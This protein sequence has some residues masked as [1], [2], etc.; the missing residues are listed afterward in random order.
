M[1]IF[2]ESE[3][4]FLN[5]Q[6]I[7]FDQYSKL[8]NT[9][10]PLSKKLLN[11]HDILN[12]IIK[13]PSKEKK[14]KNKSL[15]CSKMYNEIEEK[16]RCI[17]NLFGLSELGTETDVSSTDS[18]EIRKSTTINN[19]PEY[20][21]KFFND[22]NELRN[23]YY[24][25]L[26]EKNIITLNKESTHNTIFIYDWDDT[27]FFSSEY[28]KKKS[29]LNCPVIEQLSNKER[30]QIEII[31]EYIITI[32]TKS[33]NKGSVFII[34]DSSEGWVEASTKLFYPNLVPLLD[35]V[36]I[37]SARS[38]YEKKYPK[39]KDMW[40]LNTFLDLQRKYNFDKNKLTNI[41]CIGDNGNEIEAGKNLNKSFNNSIIKT[42][43]FQEAP[44]ID[45]LIKQLKLID[46]NFNL[47]YSFNKNT[48]III[49]RKEKNRREKI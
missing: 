7:N 6:K 32:L 47:I 43:K 16:Q 38:L 33:L 12:Q 40:K 49:D 2:Y 24:R 30:K 21:L 28:M 5:N 26:I 31:E 27:F 22:S 8:T 29:N 9:I 14:I 44:N 41:I 19:E 15:N 17:T 45:K 1:G 25:K 18:T 48:N 23:L 11:N 37:I 39:N 4:K 36:N 42:L 3:E 34:T 13:K 35:R 46:G 10:L 20:G